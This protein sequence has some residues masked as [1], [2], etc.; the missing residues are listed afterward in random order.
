MFY[1]LIALFWDVEFLW[2]KYVQDAV[3]WEDHENYWEAKHGDRLG[4]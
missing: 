1:L 4:I 2:E 3:P